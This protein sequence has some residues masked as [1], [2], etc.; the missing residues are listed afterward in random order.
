MVQQQHQKTIV[1]RQRRG[2]QIVRSIDLTSNEIYGIRLQEEYFFEE[3]NAMSSPDI[4]TRIPQIQIRR[5]APIRLSITSSIR[6]TIYHLRFLNRWIPS[7]ASIQLAHISA[8]ISFI[9]ATST[10]LLSSCPIPSSVSS[11]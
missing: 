3:H 2:L 7:R 6:P 8:A 9:C 11:G 10:R 4:R 1:E 5:Y